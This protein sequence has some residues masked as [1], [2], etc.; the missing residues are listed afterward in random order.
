MI[1]YKNLTNPN[2]EI[3]FTIQGINFYKAKL[4]TD[5]EINLVADEL[6]NKFF[7]HVDWLM[8]YTDNSKGGINGLESGE[9]E[10]SIKA[11]NS[12]L[13]DGKVIGF[14][15]ENKVFLIDGESTHLTSEKYDK[16]ADW[17]N[18]TT[19]STLTLKQR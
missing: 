13:L 15:F 10:I 4:T 18:I 11:D 19:S 7:I 1:A 17:S 2:G 5:E 8:T 6:Y 12:I 14:F 9:K 3:A 16:M